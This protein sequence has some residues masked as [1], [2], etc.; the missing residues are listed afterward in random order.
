M[1]EVIATDEFGEWYQDL[2]DIDAVSVTYTV[3]LLEQLGVNLKRPHSGTIRNSKYALREL[4]IQSKGRPLRVFY[5]FDP[6]RQAVLLVGGDKTG[7][8][9]FYD[10]FVPKAEQLWEVYLAEV[11][12]DPKRGSDHD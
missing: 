7:D 8:G 10:V 12:D 6:K 4:C 2:D 11:A 5:T 3:G 9:R 1:V